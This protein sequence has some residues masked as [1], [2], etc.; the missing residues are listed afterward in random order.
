LQVGHIIHVLL[1]GQ[2]VVDFNRLVASLLR[3]SLV[4]ANQTVFVKTGIKVLV[5]AKQPKILLF[6]RVG[7]II[8]L[9]SGE[10]MRQGRIRP[11]V[12]PLM[13]L[14]HNRQIAFVVRRVRTMVAWWIGP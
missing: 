4:S 6:R 3:L 12:M 13:Q 9:A 11:R 7:R 14:G 2:H 10:L 8:T 5:I 1:T